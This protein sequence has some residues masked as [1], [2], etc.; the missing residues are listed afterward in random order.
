M[1]RSDQIIV[2]LSASI[3]LCMTSFTCSSPAKTLDLDARVLDLRKGR[4]A[5]LIIPLALE[6]LDFTDLCCSGAGT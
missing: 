6:K 4:S 3:S 5:G 2:A 1:S